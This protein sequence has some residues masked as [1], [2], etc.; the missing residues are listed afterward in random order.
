MAF[1]AYLV[2]VELVRV[3]ALC[4][5]LW[6]SVVHLTVFLLACAVVSAWALEAD[7]GREPPAR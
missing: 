3:Q 4:L 1:V 7:G 5:C 6:C 2:F